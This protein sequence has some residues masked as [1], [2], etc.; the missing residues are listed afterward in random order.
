MRISK[1][2]M[3]C[4]SPN[5]CGGNK[6]KWNRF[7]I[8]SGNFSWRLALPAMGSSTQCRLPN[9]Q[10]GGGSNLWH[11]GAGY[12]MGAHSEILGVFASNIFTGGRGFKSM[13]PWDPLPHRAPSAEFFSTRRIFDFPNTVRLFK[14]RDLSTQIRSLPSDPAHLFSGPFGCRAPKRC[15]EIQGGG[16]GVADGQC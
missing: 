4:S 16:G 13:A 3:P 6:S 10:G 9:G 14:R 5:N 1:Q 7:E 8:A 15:R 11:L 2:P 12:R